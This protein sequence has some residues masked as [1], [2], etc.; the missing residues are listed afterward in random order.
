MEENTPKKGRRKGK[1]ADLDRKQIWKLACMQCTLREI[2]DVMDVSHE[3]IRKHF[4]DLIEQGHSVGK[5]S[6]RRAQFEKAMN[7]SDRMLV[8][9]GKQYLS[10]QDAPKDN[11]DNLPLPWED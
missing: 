11:D 10:Q 3:T 2:A 7:G 4:S 6:L 8:W 5:Q 9:L 1:A